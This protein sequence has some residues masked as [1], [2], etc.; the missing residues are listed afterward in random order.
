M[1]INTNFNR[2]DAALAIC[3]I[4]GPTTYAIVLTV[5]GA[6]WKGYDSINQS[7]S[8]L[9]AANAPYSMFMNVFGF[10]LLGLFITAFGYGLYRH[11]GKDWISKIGVALIIIGG[12]DMIIVG[13]FPTDVGGVTNSFTGFVHDITATIASNAIILGMIFMGLHFREVAKLKNYWIFTIIFAIVALSLSPF[14]LFSDDNS[15]LGLLQ[16]FGMGLALFWMVVISIKMLNL[17]RKEVNNWDLV[18]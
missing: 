13:F 7:M 18:R 3:G 12:V 2:K 15:Y 8:E 10:Q 4:V 1:S 17:I 5:P 9:G 14:P 11:F 6:Y 16:R